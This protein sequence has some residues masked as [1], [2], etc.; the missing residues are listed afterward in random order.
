MQQRAKKPLPWAKNCP[1][2]SRNDFTSHSFGYKRYWTTC[3]LRRVPFAFF[4]FLSYHNYIPCGANDS[5]CEYNVKLMCL[6]FL[7]EIWQHTMRTI[8]KLSHPTP[9]SYHQDTQQHL[10][11]TPIVQEDERDTVHGTIRYRFLLCRD[12]TQATVTSLLFACSLYAHW[13]FGSNTVFC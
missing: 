3:I 5:F 4:V 12:H 2:E 7:T 6:Q 11:E 9:S 10:N 8:E 13:C 1:D